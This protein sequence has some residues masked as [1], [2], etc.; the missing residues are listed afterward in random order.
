MVEERRGVGPDEKGKRK[1]DF[2]FFISRILE[3]FR[4]RLRGICYGFVCSKLQTKL[5]T[6]N[7]LK[8]TDVHLQTIIYEC[9]D[10]LA[11]SPRLT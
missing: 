2:P 7:Q 8:N 5:K 10:L 9:N 3:R 4:K 6:R 1:K 11:S